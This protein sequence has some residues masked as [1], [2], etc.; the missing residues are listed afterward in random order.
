MINSRR[1]ESETF[2]SAFV[3]IDINKYPTKK[4]LY[5]TK[6]TIINLYQFFSSIAS[7]YPSFFVTQNKLLDLPKIRNQLILYSHRNFLY[8]VIKSTQLF[9]SLYLALYGTMRGQIQFKKRFFTAYKKIFRRF[10]LH[11]TVPNMF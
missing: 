8:L 1:F 4:D 2:G 11:F 7:V 10:P 5:R 3:P 9:S 6:S